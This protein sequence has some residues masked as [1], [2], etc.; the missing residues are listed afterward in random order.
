MKIQPYPVFTFRKSLTTV[1]LHDIEG[2][3]SHGIDKE[4]SIVR[5]YLWGKDKSRFCGEKF[6]GD[7]GSSAIFPHLSHLSW[8][9]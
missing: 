9:A 1:S 2:S 8:R 3:V 7:G 6:C 5:R 4:C